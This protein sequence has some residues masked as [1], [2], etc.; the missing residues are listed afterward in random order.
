M[1][2]TISVG[3]DNCEQIFPGRLHERFIADWVVCFAA[4]TSRAPDLRRWNSMGRHFIHHGLPGTLRHFWIVCRKVGA[5][6]IEIQGR[7][8]IGFV[9][10]IEQAFGL[11]SLGCAKCSLFRRIVGL[12]VKNAVMPAEQ[13]VFELHVFLHVEENERADLFPLAS[14]R[15]MLAEFARIVDSL[16]SVLAIL[17]AFL[18]NPVL[19]AGETAYFKQFKFWLQR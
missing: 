12:P 6:E 15:G 4:K 9:H 5:S 8:A 3:V 7:L 1:R 18:S 19:P 17:L 2:H 10:R 11:T 14:S 13:S 16:I